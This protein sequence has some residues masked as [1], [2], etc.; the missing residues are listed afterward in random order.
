MFNKILK[1]LPRGA[2]VL[3]GI[4]CLV[5]PAMADEVA[6]VE[7]NAAA[8]ADKSIAL[9]TVWVLVAGMLVMLMQ[10]GFCYG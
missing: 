7:S 3:L 2:L 10:A 6:T 4:M 5:V 9:D 1:W 8:I